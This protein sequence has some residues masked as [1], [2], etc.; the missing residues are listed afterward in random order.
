MLL[1][2]ALALIVLTSCLLLKRKFE[3]VLP[4]LTGFFI[5]LSYFLS[6]FKLLFLVPWMIYGLALA[7]PAVLAILC[8]TKKTKLCWKDVSTYAI[9]PGCISLIATTLLYACVLRTH[10]V[11]ATDDIYY[12]AIQPKSILAQNGLVDGFHHLA[13]RFM[14][15][16][17]GMQLFQ[18]LGL[19]M[20]GEFSEGTLFV[21]L[22]IF[23][24][25]YLLPFASQITWKKAY[26][27]PLYLV[28]VLALPTVIFRDAYTMLRVDAALGICLGCALY[29]AWR[30]AANPKPA[31]FDCFGLAMTL[32]TLCLVKQIG[33]GWA[34]LPLSFLLVFKQKSSR[35]AAK[36]WIPIGTVVVV[37]AS[38]YLFTHI[39]QLSGMHNQIF[40]ETV[41]NMAASTWQAPEH[42]SQMPSAMWSAFLYCDKASLI[43]NPT[44][45]PFYPPLLL[46]FAFVIATPWL[47]AFFAPREQ[48]SAYRKLSIWWLCCSL[49]L[50]VGFAFLFLTA[51]A[52]EFDSF[53]GNADARL[54]YLLERYL[55]AFLM[56]GL[57]LSADLFT[58]LRKSQWLKVLIASCAILLLT[59]WGQLSLNLVPSNDLTQEPSDFLYAKEENY[60]LS[61]LDALENPNDAII[62]YGIDP[63]PIQRE[64]L[65][66]ALAPTKIVT[67]YGEI[68]NPDFVNLL[69]YQ[70]VTHVLCMDDNNPTYFA[71]TDFSQD[72]YIDTFTLYEVTWVNDL[73]V[74]VG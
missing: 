39:Q 27:L 65:Q 21:M 23:Y 48:K 74:L 26:Y 34:L 19:Q 20:L 31:L 64:R 60:W 58:T 43:N 3:V 28:F 18:W 61:D 17:P 47:L 46:W 24:S 33:A 68:S 72:G 69:R 12:W 4:T 66:Y 37:L 71:A 14:N 8:A 41:T 22:A 38:W 63:T 57:M 50:I 2:V 42:L 62:L 51:F 53:I 67:F 73:P 44:P 1:L 49:L 15:Y 7:L 11:T 9:T 40:Q 10:V 29:Q 45:A 70:H 25:I 59:N 13:P 32:S 56:G 35:S 6:M 54:Q 55:G 30:L 16:T 52:P 5:L 36:L